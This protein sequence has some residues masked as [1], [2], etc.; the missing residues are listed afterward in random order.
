MS[1]LCQFAPC[2]AWAYYA[3][4]VPSGTTEHYKHYRLG[5]RRYFLEH[6]NCINYSDLYYYFGS[7]AAQALKMVIRR[8][9]DFFSCSTPNHRN[10]VFSPCFVKFFKNWHSSKSPHKITA[11]YRLQESMLH[12]IEGYTTYYRKVQYI[13]QEGI[14]HT[15]G[16]YNTYI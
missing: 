8:K 10:N 12:T 14:L 7:I 6:I 15:I 11:Y 3:S 4:V 13:L 5:L 1:L 16:G 9:S 2:W